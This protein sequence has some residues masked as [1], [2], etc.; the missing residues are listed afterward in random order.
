MKTAL[1][2]VTL[3]AA[4]KVE[5]K[6]ESVWLLEYVLAVLKWYGVEPFSG[7]NAVN[8]VRSARE[9]IEHGRLTALG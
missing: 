7:E 3:Y 4:P 9:A 2:T 8:R 1:L 6:Q 5:D